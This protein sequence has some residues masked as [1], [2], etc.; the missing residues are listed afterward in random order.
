MSL[1]LITVLTQASMRIIDLMFAAP[2]KV[3]T[4]FEYCK[5]DKHAVPF[6]PKLSA[7]NQAHNFSLP[8]TIKESINNTMATDDSD[9]RLE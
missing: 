8:P 1:Y 7:L 3:C 2:T 5:P 9:P 6:L 4:W